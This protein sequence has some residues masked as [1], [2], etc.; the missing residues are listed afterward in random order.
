MSNT[1]EHKQH[2][3]Q[4]ANL[5]VLINSYCTAICSVTMLVL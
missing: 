2:S 1:M 4:T 5:Q 3:D